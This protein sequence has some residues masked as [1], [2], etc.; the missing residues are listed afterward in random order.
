MLER[1]P[2]TRTAVVGALIG[3][4]TAVLGE[5]LAEVSQRP[6]AVVVLLVL[7]MALFGLALGTVVTTFAFGASVVVMLVVE[8]LTPGPQAIVL[9]DPLRFVAFIVGSPLVI[10]LVHLAERERRRAESGR[11]DAEARQ[12]RA[13]AGLRDEAYHGRRLDEALGRAERERKRL[14][15]VAEAVPEPLI[16][17]D[18]ELRGTYGNRAARRL[19]GRS[20]FERGVDDWARAAEP[21]D[22]HGTP[23][24][25]EEWPQEQAQHGPFRRR[26]LLRIPMS[27]RDAMVD[28]EGTPIPGGGCVLLLRDVGQEEDQRRRLSGFASYVAHELRNPLAVAKARIE[29]AQ[30]AD[31]LPEKAGRHAGRALESVDTA[32]G[33]LGRLELYSRADAGG[34]DAR[35]EPFPLSAAIASS[36]EGLRARG[37]ER[38]IIVRVDSDAKVVADQQLSVQAISNLLTNADRYSTP[39][40]PIRIEVDGGDPITLRVIDAGPGISDEVAETLFR[41]RV[42]VGR[43]LGLGLYLVHATMRAMGGSVQLEERRPRAVFALRWPRA[44]A[45]SP[46]QRAPD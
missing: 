7:V 29:L 22:E 31:G 16:V 5:L 23:L 40:A 20:F 39:N 24:P 25:R 33:I 18:D 3:A 46:A 42:A 13:A 1:L 19:L 4:G 45:G 17:Y 38:E 37:S 26:L 9:A 36:V 34:I 30:R 8:L 15:E 2:P 12:L 21:R 10:V 32:I 11:L 6:N 35:R 14:E 43:G 28:V 41:D 27:G 44:R